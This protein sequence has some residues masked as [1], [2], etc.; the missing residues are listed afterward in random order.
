MEY[1]E[2]KDKSEKI[3]WW[4]S[5]TLF[6]EDGETYVTNGFV[7]H[8]SEEIATNRFGMPE[9]LEDKTVLDI[10]CWDGYFSF[11]AEKRNAKSVLGIDVLQGCSHKEQGTEGFEF[12]KKT[13]SSKVGFEKKSLEDFSKNTNKQFDVVFYYGVLYHV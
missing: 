13:L 7:N 8:C 6:S 2:I 5:I 10:G 1:Q 3:Q 9:S 12:A 4:H 11:L